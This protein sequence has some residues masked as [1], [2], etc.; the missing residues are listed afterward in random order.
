MPSIHQPEGEA[1]S[2][3]QLTALMIEGLRAKQERDTASK[4]YD[5][6]M[7]TNAKP[8]PLRDFANENPDDDLYDGESGLHLKRTSRSGIS[9][10]DVISMARDRP[11][12]LLKLAE[13]GLL[14]MNWAAWKAHP[15]EFTEALDAKGYI[16]PGGETIALEIEKREK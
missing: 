13:M 12:V 16:I 7:G 9:G 4:Y 11:H 3:R 14:T 5:Q 8:G 6:I 1:F 15:Q 2:R 10:L